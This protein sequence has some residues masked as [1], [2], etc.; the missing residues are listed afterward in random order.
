M[1]PSAAS[2]RSAV[3]RD[4][5]RVLAA[6]LDDGRARPRL[7]ER[8]E[9]A[10]PDLVRA[11]EHDAVDARV[12]LE[13]LAD[14]LARAHD[15]VDGALR[16][17]G[18]DVGLEQVLRRQ[19]RGGRRLEHDRVAGQQ[20]GAGRTGR[21]RHREVE[22]ADD[23]EDA[24]RAEDRAGVDRGVAEVAHLVVVAV[25]GLHRRGVVAQQ[26]GRFLDLAE[27]LDAVLADLERHVRG[28]LHQPFA[29]E[30][31]GALDD[32]DALA[33]R[34][35]GPGGLG[36]SGGRRRRRRRRPRCPCANVPSTMSRSIGERDLEGPVA[37]APLAVDEVAVVAA[38]ARPRLRRGRT[39]SRRGA[40]RCR[41]SAWRR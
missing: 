24:V 10:H 30:V 20:G 28:V 15:E 13:R 27:R 3:A 39:R 26:V 37:I 16:D 35:R 19:R 17:A 29:D 25:V 36:G 41:R 12:V 21:Q 1:I 18:I 8:P 40:P 31:A 11:G 23:R 4:D 22:R 9:D 7:R 33:P 32:R 34:D 6:H 5:R 38:E 14:R 2:S